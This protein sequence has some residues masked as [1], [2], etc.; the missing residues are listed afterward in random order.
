MLGWIRYAV[1]LL[2]MGLSFTVLAARPYGPTAEEARMLPDYCQNP[3]RWSAVLGPAAGWNN[4]TCFG[5]NWLNRYHK[6]R[7]SRERQYALQTAL[8]DFNYSVNK[9][10]P[11]FVLMPE[12]FMY[13]G[14]TLGLMGRVGEARA[15]LQRAIDRDP[16]LV[17][18]YNALA[19]LYEDRL[20]QPRKALEV[21]TE[22]LRHNPDTRSL[23]RRYTRLGGKLPFPEPIARPAPTP[24]EAPPATAQSPAA[25]AAPVAA[26]VP[27]PVTAPADRPAA[28]LAAERPRIGSPTNPHCR[29][30][31]D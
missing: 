19:D 27:T 10:P 8:G 3:E 22:G 30:C 7:T 6:S 16:R 11:D 20:S 4:H 1:V 26:A 28:A 12:I 17:R 25:E 23:Q 21:V 18:A 29:F 24:A 15:D 13:R 2:M 31:P 14:I 5:I 9:L